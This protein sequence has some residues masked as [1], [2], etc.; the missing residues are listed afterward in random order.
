MANGLCKEMSG[1]DVASFFCPIGHPKFLQLSISLCL[2]LIPEVFLKFFFTKERASCEAARRAK[3][4]WLPWPRISLSCRQ[5]G[6]DLTLG[7]SLVDISTNTQINFISLFDCNYREDAEDI[8][9]LISFGK[10]CLSLPGKKIF[11]KNK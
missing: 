4:L 5:Q 3:N 7:R 11:W 6:Q 9:R 2:T 10:F 1:S 8:S